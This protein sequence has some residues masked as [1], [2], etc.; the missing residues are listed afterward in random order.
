MSAKIEF[1][2]ATHESLNEV[3]VEREDLKPQPAFKCL[4]DWLKSMPPRRD[5]FPTA[6]R[7]LPLLDAMY[8]GY[9][10][11]AHCDVDVEIDDKGNMNTSY[12]SPVDPMSTHRMSTSVEFL[13]SVDSSFTHTFKWYSPWTVKTPKG[14]SCIYTHPANG[15]I[16][17]I[18]FMTSR[19]DTDELNLCVSLVFYVKK[20]YR[21]F[22]IKQGDPLVQVIPI[23]REEF[24]LDVRAA[25]KEDMFE[26]EKANWNNT[27]QKENAYRDHYWHKRKQKG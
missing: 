3:L 22:K 21:R 27:L 5:D 24:E 18:Q 10:I 20:G 9:I 16:K 8:Q 19:V 11:K 25:T 1:I 15:G 23:K 13:Q 4:P 2:A 6:K 12:T 14:Y 7:C 26:N 17:E